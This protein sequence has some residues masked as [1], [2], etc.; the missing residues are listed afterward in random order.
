MLEGFSPILEQTP[1]RNSFVTM[2]Q[3]VT[4]ITPEGKRLSAFETKDAANYLGGKGI[5]HVF[6]KSVCISTLL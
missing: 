2:Q 1:L 5:L 3:A 4:N 6:G